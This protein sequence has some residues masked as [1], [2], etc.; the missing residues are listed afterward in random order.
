MRS[1][2]LSNSCLPCRRSGRDAL[3]ARKPDRALNLADGRPKRNSTG[4][5]PAGVVFALG[6][7][8]PEGGCAAYSR[9]AAAI[10][11]VNN[12]PIGIDIT[13][14]RFAQGCGTS[15]ELSR[16]DRFFHKPIVDTEVDGIV[17]YRNDLVDRIRFFRFLTVLQRYDMQLF[18]IR[19]IDMTV[20][21][22]NPSRG[23]RGGAVNRGRPR[24]IWP[25]RLPP[26]S[27]ARRR[28]MRGCWCACW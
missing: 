25:A 11:D 22:I 3:P 13:D 7:G 27:G 16:G 10:Q 8:S 28:S 23:W 14:I 15:G 4:I 6:C 5:H 1:G 18:L 19:K 17:S 2:S 12:I 20:I 9:P 21:N 24:S 26:C